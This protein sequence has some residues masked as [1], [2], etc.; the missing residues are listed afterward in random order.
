MD[1]AL[2]AQDGSPASDS[3]DAGADAECNKIDLTPAPTIA[4]YESAA[5]TPT[6][7]GGMI[8]PGTYWAT[9]LTIYDGKTSG[10]LNNGKLSLVFGATTWDWAQEP[11]MRRYSGLWMTNNT[12]LQLGILC[13][14]NMTSGGA[15]YTVSG[16]KLM[17]FT[18]D[19]S[20]NT[21]VTEL[22]KQ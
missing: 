15:D 22:T 21:S 3:G 20:N 18:K 10:P 6:P 16:Q 13:P 9:T 19:G 5:A 11:A 7:A 1:A 4:I 17:L 8:Q 2:D 14:S 12:Y